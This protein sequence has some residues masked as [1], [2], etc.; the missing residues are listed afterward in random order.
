M[1][2]QEGEVCP[3]L[4]AET[5]TP[6]MGVGVSAGAQEAMKEAMHEGPS[7]QVGSTARGVSRLED[8]AMGGPNTIEAEVVSIS[9]SEPFDM[10]EVA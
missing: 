2:P 4:T 3:P 1:L 6:T 5:P 8:T 10:A 9:S 7:T